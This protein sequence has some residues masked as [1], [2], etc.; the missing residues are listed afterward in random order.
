M[1]KRL[2]DSPKTY[3]ILAGLFFVVGI[4]L[5]VRIEP[6]PR[7]AGTI[8]DIEGLASRDDLNVVFILI[9]TLRAD[10]LGTYGYER[11][12]SPVIDLIAQY[13]VRFDHAI[14]QSSWTKA[15]MASLWTAK[16]PAM[17]G[18][19]RYGHGLGEDV[20][21]P[22]ETF[23]E[24]GFVTAGLFRNGW[25]DPNFGF[26]QGFDVYMHPRLNEN[27]MEFRRRQ[28][29]HRVPGSDLDLTQAAVEFLRNYRHRRFM[30][31]LH[32][33]D[34]HQYAYD[35]NSALFGTRYVDYYD[36][37]IRWT[38]TNIGML[39]QELIDQDLFEKTLI[40]I[41]S[42][43]GEEFRDH[44]REGHAKT[45]YREVV[46][47][48]LIFS[49]PFRLEEELAIDTL[50]QNVD[51][52][53][54][55]L[56]L[57]GLEEPAGSTGRSL[58]PLMLGNEDGFADRAAFAQL[59]RTWG[60]SEGEPAPFV[61]V[62]TNDWKMIRYLDTDLRELYDRT[63]DPRERRNVAGR[64][65]EVVQ[66]LDQK[67]DE[68]LAAVDEMGIEPLELEVDELRLNQL[69]ALGYDIGGDN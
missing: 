1:F 6:P 13:G 18:V 3:F 21:M 67:I 61:A 19:L 12:T 4:F 7:S 65:R 25:V 22:A 38:D 66:Q 34:V 43:H 39:I 17:S 29:S 9:D 15:S 58:V 37:A 53:P 24:A 35:Q 32:Y 33:M 28:L 41:A 56:D 51:I 55:V 52:W 45:L 20:K 46:H 27:R 10:H 50:V 8:Q 16:H 60:R 57:L 49:F 5:T 68:H 47:T 59:D 64:E 54:T 63:N 42:D 2:L 69:R 11:E 14:A 62:T 26:G 40:V 48:P 31:Y 30:L 23:K 36:N 44:G